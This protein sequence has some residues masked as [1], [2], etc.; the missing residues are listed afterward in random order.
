MMSTGHSETIDVAMLNP[1]EN[2]GYLSKPIP[3]SRDLEIGNLLRRYLFDRSLLHL[4]R[5][6][7]DDHAR[8]LRAFAERSASGA[9]RNNDPEQL[10]V[11][12]I[13]LLLALSQTESRE[14]LMILAVIYDAML[15]LRLEPSAFSDSVRQV[16]GELL[17]SPFANF[18]TRSDKTLRA[19]GYEEGADSDGF[20]YVRNW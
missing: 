13:A 20:R 5:C 18:M 4:R 11:G 8:V 12:L 15:R 3:D 19:M 9:V 14:G 6:I 1:S 2:I 10:R 16:V 17:I 7:N